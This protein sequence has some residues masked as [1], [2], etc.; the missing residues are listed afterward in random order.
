MQQVT[1][2]RGCC[3]AA[4]ASGDD[5]EPANRGW[6]VLSRPGAPKLAQIQANFAPYRAYSQDI[7]VHDA[8]AMH[9]TNPAPR[10][11]EAPHPNNTERAS[12]G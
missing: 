10:S 7:Q 2:A 8:H 4:S 12:P 5:L 1:R 6:H 11:K 9:T 3:A